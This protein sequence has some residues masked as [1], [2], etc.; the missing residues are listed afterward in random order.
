MPIP[1]SV[2][3]SPAAPAPAPLA[4]G[5]VIIATDGEE[6][7]D[8]AVRAAWAIAGR[9]AADVQV[10]SVIPVLAPIVEVAVMAPLP[11]EYWQERRDARLAAVRAQL[12]R[13]IPEDCEWPV[14]I[15][16]GYGGEDIAKF[17]RECG[18]R[19]VVM[20]RGRH[21]LAQRLAAPEAVL[22]ALRF[23]D[24]PVL[25]VEPSKTALPRRIVV[26]TDFSPYSAYAARIALSFAAPD[27][28]VY[29][30]HVR[31]RAAALGP[32]FVLW[33]RAYEE[34]LP[35]I[36]ARLR[37]SLAPPPEMTIETMVL[38]GDP[39]SALLDLARTSGADLIVSGTHGRGF[40]DRLVLGSVAVDLLRGAPC[41][42]LCVPGSAVTHAAARR[43]ALALLQRTAI[44][45]LDLPGELAQ[46]SA[47]NAGRFCTLDVTPLGEDRQV[48]ATALPLVGADYDRH[49]RAL[50]L[51]L[52]AAQA[53]G[54]H[55][56]HVV[57]TVYGVDRLVDA[58]G[59]DRGL[60]IECG[61]GTVSLL[62]AP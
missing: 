43:E 48:I 30:A 7:D 17:A 14:T 22:R 42:F 37:E 2:L 29:L 56:T 53:E 61:T 21:G 5:P 50:T 47:R 19:L 33:E 20:G 34:A 8:T 36:F 39:G 12:R 11:Q 25:A 45:T 35:A 52:G 6:R 10:L 15:V 54:A 31:P 46:F 23:A 44:A 26:A 51:L 16:E 4:T 60:L 13:T 1:V 41:S 38:A 27:A 49:D 58:Q 9:T 32:A 24:V 59:V 3:E 57:H 62:L 40:V 18:A 55:L 28:I